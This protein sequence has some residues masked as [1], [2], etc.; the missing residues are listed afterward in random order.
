M[1]NNGFCMQPVVSIFRVQPQL[2][3][4][5]MD[6]LD[7]LDWSLRITGLF[8]T[9]LPSPHIFFLLMLSVVLSFYARCV[10]VLNFLP[11]RKWWWWGVWFSPW[12]NELFQWSCRTC[13]VSDIDREQHNNLIQDNS[14]SLTHAAIRQWP[15]RSWSISYVTQATVIGPPHK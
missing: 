6:H 13:I 15:R 8:S 7:C 9:F 3:F 10:L 5:M 2:C 11:G 12:T 1:K 14:K 4:W